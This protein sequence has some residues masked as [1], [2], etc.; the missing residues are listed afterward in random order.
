MCLS[1]STTMQG[2]RSKPQ[3]GLCA[4]N[5]QGL[6]LTKHQQ[7]TTCNLNFM[8]TSMNELS[9]VTS[10][11][12]Q[13]DQQPSPAA[14]HSNLGFDAIDPTSSSP[15]CSIDGCQETEPDWN[16]YSPGSLMELLNSCVECNPV[17]TTLESPGSHTQTTLSPSCDT[18]QKRDLPLVTSPSFP[19]F[20]N[21]MVSCA[22]TESSP[23]TTLNT[24][25]MAGTGDIPT[26][27]NKLSSEF[28]QLPKKPKPF[29]QGFTSVYT[30][31]LRKKL[32][33][34]QHHHHHNRHHHHHCHNNNCRVHS[35]GHTGGTSV[36]Y[37]VA[38]RCCHHHHHHHHQSQG[39]SFDHGSPFKKPM[40]TP[41]PSLTT[42]TG[43]SSSNFSSR[44]NSIASLN[45]ST[46]D[47]LLEAA[48]NSGASS[49]TPTPTASGCPGGDHSNLQNRANAPFYCHWGNECNEV[50]FT[51]END[52]D[53]H[54][55]SFHLNLDKNNIAQ[56]QPPSSSQSPGQTDN[57]RFVNK[58]SFDETC[59]IGSSDDEDDGSDSTSDKF[60]HCNWDRC[61]VELT[62]LDDILEHI[63][64]D[65]SISSREYP[66]SACNTNTNK[67]AEQ[68]DTSGEDDRNPSLNRQ[69]QYYTPPASNT[70]TPS[71][72]LP[73]RWN[74]CGYSAPDLAEL[75]T[76]ELAKHHPA[77][78]AAQANGVSLFQCEWK[79]CTYSCTDM[80]QFMTHV[81]NEH[82][83]MMLEKSKIEN[84]STELPKI[85]A[86]ENTVT[87]VANPTAAA[88]PVAAVKTET[89]S[90]KRHP[91]RWLCGPTDDETECGIV[92]DST[93]AL[94]Q[95]VI[96]HHIGSRQPSYVCRWADCDRHGRAF[97]QRQ[98]IHR[99]LITHTKNKPF[100]CSVCGAAF[101]E[102]VVL[103][104]H[105]RIHSG[106]RPFQCPEPGC[107]KRFAAS[108]ALSVHM[109]THTGEKPL[110]CKVAGCG[111]R[112]SESSNLAKHMKTH[113]AERPFGCQRCSRR[114]ARN[115]QL[116]RHIRTAHNSPGAAATATQVAATVV[117]S[118]GVGSLSSPS[119][120]SS[121]AALTT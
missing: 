95:H 3:A 84:E 120:V 73:C 16:D 56:T 33:N 5:D 25:L 77:A 7:C 45:F 89:Q 61:K 11:S 49:K 116:Q 35:D 50:F 79:A 106:E 48:N 14:A 47:K 30:R 68:N 105:M 80:D 114:F 43:S 24:N 2:S 39:N 85:K 70:P 26:L 22:N 23:S 18:I 66:H 12:F 41:A 37:G 17:N 102:S 78:T 76:H 55:K 44:S 83:S 72:L 57:N 42:E 82:V 74:G 117:A 6:D 31:N 88:D 97:P 113:Q 46:L 118:E 69:Q 103:T 99:H 21:M 9:I 40:L 32:I 65:H 110:K 98:K 36:P 107:G 91:C 20:D 13:S 52:F 94:H 8:S 119:M 15:L 104:Q 92:F 86:E 62:E 93:Q 81:R 58:R 87:V 109:R 4:Q 63:K 1:A 54:L 111:K 90:A 101:S 60:W 115:D 28:F 10:P 59:H 121:P 38:K 27:G 108:T 19:E 75:E 112:F 34:H 71:Q 53:L 96:D 67:A 51:N 64:M 100:T 29:E